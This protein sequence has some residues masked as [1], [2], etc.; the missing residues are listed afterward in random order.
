MIKVGTTT[1]TEIKKT[2]LQYEDK[3]VYCVKQS[4]I[5]SSTGTDLVY[6]DLN[7]APVKNGTVTSMSTTG[8]TKCATQGYSFYRKGVHSNSVTTVGSAMIRLQ[9]NN[10]DF[11]DSSNAR[12]HIIGAGTNP[13]NLR[14][15]KNAGADT[16]A[17]LFI[18]VGMDGSNGF[19]KIYINSISSNNLL[20]TYTIPS[21][22]LS[23]SGNILSIGV[24]ISTNI[25]TA[26]I[27]EFNL[28]VYSKLKVTTSAESEWQLVLPSTSRK[29]QIIASQIHSDG[30]LHSTDGFYY[31]FDNNGFDE[32]KISLSAKYNNK[33]TTYDNDNTIIVSSN[34]DVI[35]MSQDTSDV[36]PSLS[37]F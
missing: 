37:D 28:C 27:P 34:N 7:N 32:S 9:L 24:T 12:L 33:S 16:I 10:T 30:A 29:T 20:K 8:F 6:A 2:D 19:C 36:F 35:A 13:L 25:N 11:V 3:T 5:Q 14:F 22:T 18:S 26:N 23:T 31:Y 21:S 17:E 15:D 4:D 1:I